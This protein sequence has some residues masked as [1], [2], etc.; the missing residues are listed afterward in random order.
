MRTMK[1]FF[2]SHSSKD[3]VW[4]EWIA[5]QLEEAGYTTTLDVWDFRP[6][7]NFGKAM[8]TALE[9]CER[10]LAVLSPNY[11]SGP[12]AQAEWYAAFAEDPL[13]EQGKLL[14]VRVDRIELKGLQKPLGS[15][16]GFVRSDQTRDKLG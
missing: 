1:D 12:F 5:Y 11:F 2:V 6:G 10:I 15:C 13:G 14:P 4:A 9:E 3:R 16:K 8:Q 7:T